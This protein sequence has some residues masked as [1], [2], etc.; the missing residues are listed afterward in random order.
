[1]KGSLK[2]LWLVLL[3]TIIPLGFTGLLT[4]TV[5]GQVAKKGPP[6][7]VIYFDV[8]T[9]QDVGIG[10][11]AT[12]ITDVFLWS[13][14]EAVWK[15]TSPEIIANLKLIRTASGYWCLLVNPVEED[16]AVPGVV[17]TTSGEVHFNPFAIR[18]V[19]YAMNWLIDRKYIIEEILAG[20]GAPM[21]SSVQ[22]SQPAIKKV[23]HI[24]PE[25]GLDS[26][27]NFNWANQ[28]INSALSAAAKTLANYG[29]T[30]EPKPDAS[31]P[32]G[33]WWTFK[34]NQTEATEETVT[35]KFFIRTEDER[36]EEGLYV[37]DLIEKTGI[38]VERLERDRTVS[39][40]TV[41]YT[42]PKDYLWN[43]Y[44]EGWVSMSEWLYPEWAIAQMYAPWVAFMPGWENPPG[45]NT[46]TPP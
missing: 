28:T 22:P 44:T 37:A 25:L 29:Y 7:D 42:D 19:R 33:F 15:R 1:M 40:L 32:A 21:Y 10:D 26:Q 38:K 6:L 11:T 23:E 3:L 13:T 30:L 2:T 8:R 45:G 16:S 12:G 43:I 4:T 35:V 46:K 9:S 14:S 20:G 36:H 5:E 27:G 34:G 18:E 41:Y 24:Y 17:N 31:A 39:A